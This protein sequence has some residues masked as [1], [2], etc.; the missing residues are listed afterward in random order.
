MK[1]ETYFNSSDLI[2]LDEVG[3]SRKMTFLALLREGDALKDL[4]QSVINGIKNL[5]V[6]WEYEGDDVEVDHIYDTDT[7]ELYRW[8]KPADEWTDGD[9]LILC[10][11]LMYGDLESAVQ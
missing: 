10:S 3:K 8:D 4:P 1:F 11:L 6:V 5:S 9:E 2:E 7:G